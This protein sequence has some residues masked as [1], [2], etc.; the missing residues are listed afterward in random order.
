MFKKSKRIFTLYSTFNTPKTVLPL[1]HT[2]SQ[3]SLATVT[4]TTC[5][6][7]L[8]KVR[9]QWCTNGMQKRSFISTSL[10]SLVGTFSTCL[11]QNILIL[12]H[13]G[14][15]RM[16]PTNLAIYTKEQAMVPMYQ[17]YHSCSPKVKS[18]YKPSFHCYV[19]IQWNPS[20][21]NTL[22]CPKFALLV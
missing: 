20:R 6:V 21:K 5:E 12:C 22:L 9:C 11:D 13:C 18:I 8:M 14:D 17:L 16:W 4:I 15:C 2:H 1:T 7:R 3:P 19:L 10:C